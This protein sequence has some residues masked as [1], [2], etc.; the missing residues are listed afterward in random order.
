MLMRY[1]VAFLRNNVAG[2][3][4]EAALA[5]GNP[6]IEDWMSHAQALVLARSGQLQMARK[7]S[8][9]AIVLARQA[10]QKR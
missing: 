3:D 9:R 2:M 5:A 4:R 6:G 1:H 8:D 7:M 10:G